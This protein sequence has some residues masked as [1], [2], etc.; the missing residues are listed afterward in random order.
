[1]GADNTRSSGRKSSRSGTDELLEDVLVGVA[2]AL[3]LL[4]WWA[5]RFPV[6][7]IPLVVALAV[8]VLVG[9]W[10]GV[11]AVS[12]C[13]FGYGAWG[14]LDPASFREATWIPIR[15]A[16]LTWW[17]YERT[18]ETVCTL[19]GLTARIS[20]RTLVPGLQLVQ[21]GEGV[22]RLTVRILTGQTAATW[23]RQ[24][25]ALADTWRS[26]RV[27][28]RSARP[29]EVTI[30]VHHGDRLADPLPLPRPT[31]ATPV[32]LGEVT[33]GATET[34]QPW[35]FP[36]LGNHG[37][38]AGATGSG[39][40]SVLHSIIAALAPGVRAGLVRLCVV[41]PKG[42]MELGRGARLFTAFTHDHTENTLGL[43]QA[44]V[45]VMTKRAAR[46]RGR[47]RLHTPTVAE[48]LLVVIIDELASLTAYGSDRKIRTDIER[49]LGLLLSQGR[50]VGVSVI[51]AVQDPAKDTL[52]VRHLF[53]V[54]VGLRMTE[55]TQTAM[56]LGAA[57]REGGAI[58]EHIPASTPGV[59]YVMVDGTGEPQRVRA[60]HVTDADIDYLTAQFVPPRRCQKSDTS[61]H[62]RVGGA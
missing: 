61:E 49:L 29:G 58:C 42:G 20:E 38:I 57:G 59:G 40:G 4:V 2:K 17:R 35:R 30:R 28:V 21:I 48:P 24:D 18:W 54:R 8:T 36:V 60:Y 7:S 14:Y 56:V 47:T 39:K 25:A 52:S 3:G 43:L 53:T 1:M 33:I 16:W 34:G 6:V 32:D 19:H 37:L 50:A 5:I 27:T 9:W 12:T 44:L 31:R 41:D 51:A 23:Q 45:E 10:F 22:D 62:E 46:L 26:P 15:T 55:A 11:V 13:A